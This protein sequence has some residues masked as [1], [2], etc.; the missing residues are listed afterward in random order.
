[1]DE[2]VEVPAEDDLVVSE[3]ADGT[4]VVE[5]VD[6]SEPEQ[7]A[8]GGQVEDD[9]GEDHP[10]DTEAIRASRREKRKL[11]KQYHRQQQHEKDI[12][13]NQLLKQNQELTQRLSLVEQKTHGTEIARIDKAIE[14]Q[15]MKIQWAKMKMS[16]ATSSQ[17]GNAMAEA[18][19]VWF[20]ARRASE[21]LSNL[22]KQSTTPR[23]QANL[24]D[25]T[26]QRLAANWMEKNPWYDPSNKDEDSEIALT[27]DKRM[28]KEGWDPRSPEYWEELDNRLQNR[29]PH[30]YNETS[31]SNYVRKPRSVVTGSGRESVSQHGGKVSVTLPAEYVKNLKDA[32]MWDNPATR[33]KMINSYVAQLKTNRS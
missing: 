8:D 1:M 22:K 9:G 25:P 29:L 6:S 31:E 27:V 10:D 26:M 30:R 3:S 15:E 21:A 19:E 2:K 11:K 18:Q 7:K 24:P 13:Y 33:K 23:P 4:V 17:D 5:G 12:K 32:G 16:E 20:E 28:A 14:D